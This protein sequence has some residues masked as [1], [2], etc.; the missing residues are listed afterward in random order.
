M[1]LYRY[2]AVTTFAYTLDEITLLLRFSLSSTLIFG[3]KKLTEFTF[4]VSGTTADDGMIPTIL[5]LRSMNGRSFV[6][7]CANIQGD[8]DEHVFYFAR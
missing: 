6:S 2:S 8:P 7:K 4:S 1:R 5:E 3:K